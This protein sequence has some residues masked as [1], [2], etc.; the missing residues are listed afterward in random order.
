MI[1]NRSSKTPEATSRAARQ[2]RNL[3]PPRLGLQLHEPCSARRSETERYVADQFL[4][5]HGAQIRE[6]MPWLISMHC[7]ERRIAAVGVRPAA[8]QRLFLEH[9]LSR[10][11]EDAV[12]RAAGQPI[13]R[14]GIAEIGNLVATQRGASQLLFL[15]LTAFLHQERFEWVVFTATP[16]VR[17]TLSRLGFSLH[18]LGQADLSALEPEARG[19]W[20]TYYDNRPVVIAGH[21]PS[22]M[23]LL[24]SRR[25]QAALLALFRR[26]VQSLSTSRSPVETAHG[27]PAFAV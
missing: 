8:S 10:S 19:A 21:V 16:A 3:V 26:Q 1:E 18:Q 4:H 22:G 20:G 27:T 23:A 24:A 5:V 2:L 11:V 12:G 7:G 9:Y 13:V 25:R 6:F 14:T 15:L 17:K